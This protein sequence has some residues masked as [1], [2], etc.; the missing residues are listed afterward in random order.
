MSTKHGYEGSSPSRGTDSVIKVNETPIE[1]MGV[2]D[3]VSIYVG[4][5]VDAVS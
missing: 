1:L 5:W 2:S 3:T 4:A